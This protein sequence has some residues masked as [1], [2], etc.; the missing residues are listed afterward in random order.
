MPSLLVRMR[1]GGIS[2]RCP[3]GLPQRLQ[4]DFGRSDTHRN[5]Q[6]REAQ[7]TAS[8]VVVERDSLHPRSTWR[9]RRSF[10]GGC[11]ELACERHEASARIGGEYFLRAGGQ[12]GD[13]SQAVGT[14]LTG[15]RPTLS[16]HLH[17]KHAR[18][19]HNS[20]AMPASIWLPPNSCH[21]VLI[22]PSG[23]ITPSGTEEL[24]P[25]R[26]RRVPTRGGSLGRYSVLP[27]AGRRGR[28]CPGS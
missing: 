20:N 25:Q 11:A 3:A 8:K 14:S 12:R 28:A 9:V 16:L 26:A 27:W 1:G 7:T 13:T 15:R 21:G 22:P 23:S 5:H 10:R 19:F 4:A 17:A 24:T 18:N 6:Q 2:M